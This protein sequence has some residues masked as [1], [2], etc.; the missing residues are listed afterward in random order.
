MVRITEKIQKISMKNKIID[1][2]ISW[3]KHNNTGFINL[4]ILFNKI[5]H[6]YLFGIIFRS[7][8]EN[9]NKVD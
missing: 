8:G 7:K 1:N 5:M 2:R 6:V 3:R 9:L 4:G